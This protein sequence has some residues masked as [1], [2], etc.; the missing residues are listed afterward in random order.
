MTHI[1]RSLPLILVSNAALA[2]EAPH[3][4]P[5]LGDTNWLPL[6]VGLLVIACAAALAGSR[7]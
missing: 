3:L 4:H 1:L 6:A 2:H 5:H 7:K